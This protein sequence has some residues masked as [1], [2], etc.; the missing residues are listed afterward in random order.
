M[1]RAHLY[2]AT[3]IRHHVLVSMPSPSPLTLTL[4]YS[5]MERDSEKGQNVVA[6]L[7]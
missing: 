2:F 1:K 6:D 3:A 4:G 5:N 7:D